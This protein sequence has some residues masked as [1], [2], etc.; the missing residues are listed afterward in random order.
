M[1]QQLIDALVDGQPEQAT[2]ARALNLSLRQLQR[3]LSAQGTSFRK[4]T[5][6]VRMNLAVSYLSERHKSIGE[7]SWLL[8]YTEP[9]NFSR[10]FKKWTGQTPKAF[11]E[12]SSVDSLKKTTRRRLARRMP[13]YGAAAR[14]HQARRPQCCGSAPTQ[15]SG[16]AVDLASSFGGDLEGAQSFLVI[17]D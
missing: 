6:E 10:S 2:V 1:R 14:D 5:D 7:I 11:R 3:E 4:L 13:A 15:G 12:A 17:V 16:V 9:A 8:G